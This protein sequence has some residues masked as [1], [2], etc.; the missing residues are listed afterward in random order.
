M[1]NLI[2]SIVSIFVATAY[3]TIF[4]PIALAAGGCVP[5]YGG[6]VSCPPSECVPVYGG[7]VSCPTQSQVLV[8]KKVKNPAT[9]IFVDNLGPNDPKYRTQQVISFKLIVKNSGDKPISK[10]TVKDTIPSYVDFMTGPG[11]FDK[12]SRVLTFVV[13]DLAGGASQEFEVK[14]RTVHPAVLPKDK[15]VV[16]QKNIVDAL[17]DTQID[18]DDAQ[19]CIEKKI[20]IARQPEAGPEMWLVS[21]TGLVSSLAVGLKL[22]RKTV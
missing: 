20:E 14:G 19:F 7:G 6:G 9:D 22:R 15:N 4:S 10:L 5:V 3:V 11:N 18:R 16:C 12:D 8:D 21:I 2:V 13:N 17:S 1:K